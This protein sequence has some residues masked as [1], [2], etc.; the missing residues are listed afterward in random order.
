MGRHREVYL[1]KA[2]E[3]LQA[4]LSDPSCLHDLQVFGQCWM[5]AGRPPLSRTHAPKLVDMLRAICGAYGLEWPLDGWLIA[6]FLMARGDQDPRTPEEIRRPP[7]DRLTAWHMAEKGRGG[8]LTWEQRRILNPR[9]PKGHGASYRALAKY[10]HGNTDT[11]EIHDAIE[12]CRR[13]DDL[14]KY[15]GSYGE[16]AQMLGKSGFDPALLQELIKPL[17]RAAPKPRK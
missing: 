14:C 16:V 8:D 11:H 15:T 4:A 12:E 5:I 17:E 10:L 7:V 3:R 13:W 1:R 9:P 6:W 2:G